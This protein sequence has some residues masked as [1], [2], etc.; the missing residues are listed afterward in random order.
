MMEANNDMNFPEKAQ[1]EAEKDNEIRYLRKVISA[2]ENLTAYNHQELMQADAMMNAQEKVQDYSRN[3]IARLRHRIKDLELRE[4]GLQQRIKSALEEESISET[5]IMERLDMLRGES[6]NSFYVDLFR[7]LMHCDFD[8]DEAIHHW[9]GVLSNKDNMSKKLGRDVSFR[10]ALMDYFISR[11][12]FL[13]NPMMIEISVFDEVLQ[14][15]LQDELTRLYNRR[16]FDLTLS[17]EINRGR[18]H[19]HPVT[20]LILDIDDFKKYNDSHGHS[21]GDEIMREVG[22]LMRSTFRSEDVPCRFGGEEFVVILP[23]TASEQAFQVAQRFFDALEHVQL[24]TGSVTMSGGIAHFPNH[25]DNPGNLL[26]QADRALYKAKENG[27][28]Q[29]VIAG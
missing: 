9:Q 1:E 21:A 4:A 20:L 22:N 19:Q 28:N 7:V 3:E 2:Y 23:E 24:E 25:A 13:K 12:K 27:K 11:N 26:I 14:S 16:Y 6:D 15:S 8:E 17:R 5:M 29:I 10:V 18:R